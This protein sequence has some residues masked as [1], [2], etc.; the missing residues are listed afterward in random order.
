[1]LVCDFKVF[2]I[3]CQNL[4]KIDMFTDKLEEELGKK[5]LASGQLSWGGE[6]R[7]SARETTSRNTYGLP[8]LRTFNF[9]SNGLDDMLEEV[10]AKKEPFEKLLLP[11][12]KGMYKYLDMYVVCFLVVVFSQFEAS[13]NGKKRWL[14]KWALYQL[15]NK[16]EIQLINALE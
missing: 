11:T 9:D 10:E 3:I 7:G 5:T 16:N 4:S 13:L 12:L 6:E 2:A 1:M 14:R 8:M 15:Q